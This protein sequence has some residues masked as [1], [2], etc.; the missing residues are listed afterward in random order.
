MS[1]NRHHEGVFTKL[2]AITLS[3]DT[4]IGGNVYVGVGGDIEVRAQESS[5][6]VV[7]KNYPTGAW[8][9]GI[10]AEIRAS[11]TTASDLVKAW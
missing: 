2:T 7:L 9:P 5:A 6:F 8:I 11:G 3:G 10:V 1:I 4:A